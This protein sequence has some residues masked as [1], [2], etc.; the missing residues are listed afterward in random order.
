M[1]FRY[2]TVFLTLLI[3]FTCIVVLYVSEKT[4]YENLR[5]SFQTDLS[6][7][8]RSYNIDKFIVN[9]NYN[10]LNYVVDPTES[11]ISRIECYGILIG[12]YNIENIT[13]IDYTQTEF[14]LL[15]SNFSSNYVCVFGYI[16]LENV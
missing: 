4:K 5:N 9:E 8:A 14:D 3:A 12:T 6:T 11:T 16:T 1:D 10:T 7:M 2:I 15:F 13:N